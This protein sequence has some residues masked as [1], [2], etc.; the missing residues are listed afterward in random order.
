MARAI[1]VQK[2]AHDRLERKGKGGATPA[3][4]AEARHEP[5]T[6][7]AP[8]IPGE[9]MIS[10]VGRYHVT[11]GNVTTRDT[12]A[13]LFRRPPFQLT[14]WVPPHIG[15]LCD[16]FSDRPTETIQRFLRES[17][18][19]PLFEMFTGAQFSAREEQGHIDAVLQ[20]LPK[21]MVGAF[22]WT[23][24]CPQCLTDDEER[25]GTPAIIS[26]HQIPG[27]STCYRH[28]T[29]LLD[30]CPHCRCPFERRD[31]LVL[32]PWHG[33]S[34]CHRRLIGE[35]I[36]EGPATTED[37]ATGFARFAA[38]LL[39]S[40]LRGASREGLVKLYRAGIKGQGLTRGSVVDRIELIRQL[41]DQ[42]GE[43]LVKH[44]D[45]AYRSDRL[46][47]W[48]HILIASTT[49]EAP[50]GRHLLLSYFLYE[51]AD[52]FLSQYRQIALGQTASVGLRIARPSSQEATPRSSDL[53][54]QVVDASKAI[55]NCDLDALWREH[56]GL[57]K[58]LV[59]Q[60][61]TALDELQRKLEQNIGR[62]SKPAK[63]SVL[64][65][66]PDDALWAEKLEQ[67]VPSFYAGPEYPQQGT[68]N[69][70]LR[71]IGWKRNSSLDMPAF[72]QLRSVLDTA[73]ES[74]WHFYIRRI[75]WALTQ[76][77]ARTWAPSQIGKSAGVEWHKARALIDYCL[78]KGVPRNAD[79]SSVMTI[80]RD[81]QID[82]NWEGPCPD[83][84]FAKAGRDYQRRTR[85]GD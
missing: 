64:G 33:C 20:S 31:D 67:S 74:P 1:K 52:R 15:A 6:L 53:M 80:L 66:H 26:A 58:R 39:E 79:P 32:V 13:E 40:G 24:L 25:Y 7:C 71:R 12:Y 82:R 36:Q 50:L 17:T 70:L 65:P 45:P 68:R 11:S 78:Q 2:A 27:V 61:P 44:V 55:P 85:D 46:S 4:L 72:P 57:M 5:L 49:W 18:L 56:Y 42:F 37:Y 51:D 16:R 30:R 83:R 38:R 54:E 35:P 29:P 19:F 23:R 59:R 81:W 76:S 9:S 34:A 21:R 75:L 48:F 43:A 63:R 73:C 84:V 69:R 28:G 47:G 77:A 10:Q 14:L 60:N 62:K 22:G 41:V 8:A 3:V